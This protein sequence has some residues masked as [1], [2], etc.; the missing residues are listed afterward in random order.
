MRL[1]YLGTTAKKLIK[2]RRIDSH[3]NLTVSYQAV[4]QRGLL[5]RRAVRPVTAT[6]TVNVRAEVALAIAGY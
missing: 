2:T 4:A 6:R 1:P 3:G 5:R